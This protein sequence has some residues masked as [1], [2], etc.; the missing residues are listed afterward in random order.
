MGVNILKIKKER[1]AIFKQEQ[2]YQVFLLRIHSRRLQQSIID[3]CWHEAK[4]SHQ[5]CLMGA[6][7]LE[8]FSFTL[9]L[10]V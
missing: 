10:I 3:T 9:K 5:S 7:A 2:L 8:L 1:V 4:Q 6:G